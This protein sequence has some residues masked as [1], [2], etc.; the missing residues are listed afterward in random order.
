M[1]ISHSLREDKL[2]KTLALVF[3]LLIWAF[4][5][6]Q[7]RDVEIFRNVPVKIEHSGDIALLDQTL[8]KIAVAVRGSKR[9]V[10]VITNL[11]IEV[12]GQIPEAAQP[13][14][15][16]IRLSKKN[17]RTP[18]GVEVIEVTPDRVQVNVDQLKTVEKPVRHRFNGNLPNEY[19]FK[20]VVVVPKRVQVTGP[21]RL[22]DDLA[23]V[24][25]GPIELG[26]Q[27]PEKFEMSVGLMKVPQV[28]V[29]PEE[30]SVQV[31]LYRQKGDKFFPKLDVG[32]LTPKSGDFYVEGFVEPSQP[33]VEAVIQGP[34]SIIDI[35]TE[36]SLRPFIDLSDITAA[37]T[38]RKRVHLWIN[39]ED[40]RVLE[41]KPIILKVKIGRKPQ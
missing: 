16:M 12:I 36:S 38:Y 7:I 29:S 31:E 3:A 5:R 35:L 24:I 30:V 19:A 39:A 4:V 41:I 33:V 25:T 6:V 17:V 26:E 11:D 32:V 10:N 15:V 9:R 28:N 20:S 2:R 14:S 40:C 18:K 1:K 34:T 37:G 27:T 21:A 8:P 13:G 22:V 23:E